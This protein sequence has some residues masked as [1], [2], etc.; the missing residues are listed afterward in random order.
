[1]FEISPQSKG[2]L[3]RVGDEQTPVFVIDNFMVNT[4]DIIQEAATLNYV[5]GQEHNN[6]YPGIR[7]PVSNEYGM[8][9]L[10]AIA[11]IFYNVL[12]IPKNLTLYP[13]I[14]SFSLLTQ[15]EDDMNLFQCIPHFDNTSTFS[16]AALHYV[17]NGNFGGTAFYKHKPTGF[18][19]IT[20]SNKVRYMEAAQEFI[21]TN[22]EPPKTYITQSTEHYELL[23][24]I[25]Y[26][27]N[28]LVIYPSSLLHSTFIENPQH[29]VNNDVKTG[30]LTSNFFIDFA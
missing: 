18:E 8:A 22:G 23:K 28:R 13:K 29:D 25:D 20:E 11:P 12:K 14:A 6:Y 17:N 26:K 7:A 10:N 16:F 21:D 15:K 27:P 5:S 2:S 24:V 1:M 4:T 19:N 3:I 9:V 30:R